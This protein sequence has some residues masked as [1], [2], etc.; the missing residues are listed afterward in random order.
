MYD[1][2]VL[3]EENT[4]L[5]PPP[6]RNQDGVQKR[7]TGIP[8]DQSLGESELHPLEDMRLNDNHQHPIKFWSRDIMK[9]MR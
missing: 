8:E 9:R 7:V 4:T 1:D 6:F 3:K 5:R 2:N